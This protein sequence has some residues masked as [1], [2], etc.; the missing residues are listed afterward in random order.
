MCIAQFFWDFVIIFG[1]WDFCI[2]V[3]IKFLIIASVSKIE[4]MQE[5]YFVSDFCILM[6]KSGLPKMENVQAMAHNNIAKSLF[7]NLQI[8][9]F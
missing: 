8:F 6:Q 5:L 4:T 9:T 1:F 3:R 2:N 7:R